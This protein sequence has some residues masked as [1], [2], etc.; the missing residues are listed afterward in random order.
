MKV[1]NLQILS[2]KYCFFQKKFLIALSLSHLPATLPNTI[3]SAI[4]T[5][6]SNLPL[7]KNLLPPSG[8]WIP[9]T[10]EIFSVY[11]P[12]SLFEKSCV[13]FLFQK[14]TIMLPTG[15]SVT[16]ASLS[17]WG[18]PLG[19]S[20]PSLTLLISRVREALTISLASSPTVTLSFWVPYLSSVGRTL[21]LS[22]KASSLGLASKD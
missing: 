7:P 13:M 20:L 1:I 22:G 6:L 16:Q 18:H 14:W 21:R 4:R 2:R 10:S 5:G 8:R 3:S 11:T 15:P 12:E 9:P 17:P 19:P